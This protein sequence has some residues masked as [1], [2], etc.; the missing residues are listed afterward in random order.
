MARCSHA[1]AGAYVVGRAGEVSTDSASDPSGVRSVRSWT[2][3]VIRQREAARSAPKIVPAD[4]TTLLPFSAQKTCYFTLWNME[5]SEA[6]IATAA[7]NRFTRLQEGARSLHPPL[8]S[9]W[10][11]LGPSRPFRQRQHNAFP[12]LSAGYS[13][14]QPPHQS[15]AA[16]A[17]CAHGLPLHFVV[18]LAGKT[19]MPAMPTL[20][21][22]STVATSFRTQLL[23]NYQI[24]S[25]NELKDVAGLKASAGTRSSASQLMVCC[26]DHLHQPSCHRCIYI[27]TF[28]RVLYRSKGDVAQRLP[29]VT[30]TTPSPLNWN[31]VCSIAAG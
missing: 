2:V 9:A 8:I 18:L 4:L 5:A 25:I 30:P 7:S 13:T 22:L 21:S 27:K 20:V 29:P 12:A 1:R 3:R 6:G 16:A 14:Q 17:M 15:L 28:T 26:M 19:V 10:A 24:P 11:T 31:H 23:H